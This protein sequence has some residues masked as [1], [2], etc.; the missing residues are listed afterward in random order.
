MKI[1]VTGGA[2]FIGSNFILKQV[3]DKNNVVLNY[4]KLTYAGNVQNLKSIENNS[5]YSFVKGDV[6]DKNK[7]NTVIEDFSPDSIINFAAES[8][9]DRSIDGPG[10]FIRTNIN[11]TYELLSASLDYYNRLEVERQK[12]FRFLHISTDEVYGSLGNTGKFTEETSYDPSSP[13]SA[14]KAASDHLVK[15][16]GYTYKLPILITNC[17]NNYGPFQFPEKLVPLII[18]NCINHKPLPIYGK[19]DNIRDWIY[20]EDHCMGIYTVLKKGRVGETYNIG[21]N[22]EL[23]NIHIVRKICNILD[24]LYPSNKIDSYDS[25]ITFVED[26]PGHDFRYA[27]DSSKIENELGFYPKETL[28]S[29][30]RKTISWYLN[31]LE[32]VNNIN[33]GT[34]NQERLGVIKK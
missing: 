6:N 1:L 4:D 14:S 29:G 34:Y 26:R 16:W 25:L 17:S 8:H 21:G 24:G 7:L 30:L 5:S 32:W 12:D 23:S 2:G 31:N 18:S 22:Q 20:V 11:G 33:N 28:E 19:G 15:A 27:I 13:Y 10:E 9:V 3:N